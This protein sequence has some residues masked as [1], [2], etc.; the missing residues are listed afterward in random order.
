MCRYAEGFSGF[1]FMLSVTDFSSFNYP[2]WQPLINLVSF[3][4]I[5]APWLVK[6]AFYPS[7]RIK[8]G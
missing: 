4:L 7:R 5:F 6:Y 1:S 2:S 3:S 8:Y